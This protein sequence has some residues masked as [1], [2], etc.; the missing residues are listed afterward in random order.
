MRESNSVS[1]ASTATSAFP[2]ATADLLLSHRDVEVVIVNTSVLP[3]ELLLLVVLLLVEKVEAVPVA[4]S[5]SRSIGG[6]QPIKALQNQR[7]R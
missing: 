3:I 2:A 6:L 7:A 4:I 1:D 5:L